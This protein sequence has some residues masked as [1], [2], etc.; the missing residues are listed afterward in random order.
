MIYVSLIYVFMKKQASK[1]RN[2]SV[3]ETIFD[4]AKQ[5]ASY[6]RIIIKWWQVITWQIISKAILYDDK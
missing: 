5:S 3:S 4:R 1:Q 6:L 2:L